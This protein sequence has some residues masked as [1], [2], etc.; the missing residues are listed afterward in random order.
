MSRPQPFIDATFSNLH[1]KAGYDFAIWINSSFVAAGSL[2]GLKVPSS[3][4]IK[5]SAILSAMIKAKAMGFSKVYILTDALE[6]V[7]AI[8]G[9]SD[10]SIDPILQDISM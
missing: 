9:N 2:N 8:K 6:D 3:K 10:G 4:E 7:H 5:T 1:G